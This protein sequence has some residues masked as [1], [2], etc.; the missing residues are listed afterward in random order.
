MAPWAIQPVSAKRSGSNSSSTLFPF[1]LGAS[2]GIGVGIAL[3][4]SLVVVTSLSYWF[5]RY[6]PRARINSR[7]RN[8]TWHAMKPCVLAPPAAGREANAPRNRFGRVLAVL[9][10]KRRKSR[11]DLNATPDSFLSEAG[12][13]PLQLPENELKELPSHRRGS[14]AELEGG[15]FGDGKVLFGAEE[16]DPFEE[17]NREVDAHGPVPPYT[18]SAGRS[19]RDIS[20]TTFAS[21]SERDVSSIPHYRPEGTS[22]P[23]PPGTLDINKLVLE[24]PPVTTA[25]QAAWHRKRTGPPPPLTI[26]PPVHSRSPSDATSAYS[27]FA[28]P[29]S[30]Y[31]YYS[32]N[33]PVP[34]IPSPHRTP[35]L[36]DSF[37]SDP[38]LGA[39]HSSHS[40]TSDCS[41]HLVY[42]QASSTTPT[43]V[44]NMSRSNSGAQTASIS[45]PPPTPTYSPTGSLHSPTTQNQKVPIDSTNIVCLGPLPSD[46][47]M[48]TPG[49]FQAGW[50]Q[51]GPYRSVPRVL[52]AD[53]NMRRPATASSAG[54]LSPLTYQ[55]PLLH[56]SN[57]FRP[58]QNP[59]NPT[60]TREHSIH[61]QQELLL[62]LEREEVPRQRRPSA[63]S[64]GS[65]FTVEEEA[66]IQ[67]QIVKNLS[68]I[69]KERVIG[70][71]DIVHIP[72]FSDKR[73][74][75]EN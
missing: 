44:P 40:S 28:A 46:S 51:Q 59:A 37:A 33:I 13:Q 62:L 18:C 66:R 65:N 74:S 30:P 31:E 73:Y 71:N 58:H 27:T 6:R 15:L 50:Q 19:E 29:S 68:M 26:A 75:W 1:S 8:E 7:L 35:T 41:S 69:G 52:A 48:P 16:D 64:L 22:T 43:S 67:A 21:K 17:A 24:M 55:D 45:L 42:D 20:F 32:F 47:L 23:P 25:P 11:A 60:F 38:S 14:A 2:V 34:A 3:I 56:D 72:Q 39:S 61:A 5:Y 9:S 49:Q 36:K 63:D 53:P 70:G 54:A 57:P 12:L 10:P 4:V